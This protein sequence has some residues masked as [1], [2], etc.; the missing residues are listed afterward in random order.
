MLKAPAVVLTQRS[1]QTSS[2]QV[3]VWYAYAVTS[4]Y[5]RMKE[6]LEYLS[7]KLHL[8]SVGTFKLEGITRKV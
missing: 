7:S 1:E 8:A 5:L 3:V 6:T 2:S 4:D